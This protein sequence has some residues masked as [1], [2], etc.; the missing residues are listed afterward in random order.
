M[1]ITDYTLYHYDN[2]PLSQASRLTVDTAR[3]P[4]TPV[5]VDLHDKPE[6]FAKEVNPEGKV[7]V[8]KLGRPEDKEAI[9][10]PESWAI[11]R[12]VAD[13]SGK[14]LPQD[15]L[16]RARI[17]ILKARFE[18]K[19]YKPLYSFYST[20]GS[21]ERKK[22]IQE[23]REGLAHIEGL[24]KDQSPNGPYFLG[25]ELSLADTM[26]TPP[27][28]SAFAYLSSALGSDLDLDQY[29]RLKAWVQTMKS[30]PEW[31]KVVSD[32]ATFIK[33]TSA[34]VDY[35]EMVSRQTQV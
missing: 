28:A 35:L 34:Y 4:Y 31:S 13:V 17:E 16:K 27:L 6:Y 7:P 33:N 20:F 25:E 10:L 1:T 24:V 8:L 11:A 14:L 32:D 21:V 30:L 5:Q 3:I 22:K 26:V 23:I 29:P 15:P 12:Y 9:C 2:S 19:L 18:E